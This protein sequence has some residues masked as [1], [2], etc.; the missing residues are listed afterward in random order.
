MPRRPLS[1]GST[2]LAGAAAGSLFAVA[3]AAGA[4]V[5]AGHSDPAGAPRAV[6]LAEGSLSI[7]DSR[8]GAAILTTGSLAPGHALEGTLTIRNTG[9]MPGVLALSSTVAEALGTRD[10]NLLDALKLRVTEVTDTGPVVVHDGGLDGVDAPDLGVVSPGTGRTYRFVARLPAGDNARD[11]RMQSASVRLAY[12]WRLTEVPADPVDPPVTVPDPVDPPVTVPNP[13][14]PPVTPPDP[15]GPPAV[16]GPVVPPATPAPV[17]VPVPPGAGATTP[18]DPSTKPDVPVVRM[19]TRSVRLDRQGRFATR[20]SCA[21][22]TTG[23]RVRVRMLRGPRTIAS[24]TVTLRPGRTVL[25]RTRA[26]PEMLRALRQGRSV[27]VRM[28][29]RGSSSTRAPKTARVVVRP[30]R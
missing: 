19:L 23:C 24:R 10:R 29:F 28:T 22:G 9:T 25:L 6:A 4:V 12:A 7:A 20:I 8:D 2:A 26:T 16:P 27:V 1:R 15:G 21:R 5:V 18:T 11:N 3:V 17:P 30:A 14:V 13:V